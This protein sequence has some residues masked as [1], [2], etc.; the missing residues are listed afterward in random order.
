MFS[1][2][3]AVPQTALCGKQ[4]NCPQYIHRPAPGTCECYISWQEDFAGGICILVTCL[5]VS[6]YSKLS[7]IGL[8]YVLILLLLTEN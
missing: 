8:I 5:I 4:N 7:I 3:D 1:N 2:S 6:K